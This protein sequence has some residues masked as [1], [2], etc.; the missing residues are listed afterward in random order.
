MV[1]ESWGLPWR[2]GLFAWLTRWE[3]RTGTHTVLS[4]STNGI[5]KKI[6]RIAKMIFI[7]KKQITGKKMKQKFLKENSFKENSH[8]RLN[9]KSNGPRVSEKC[10]VTK[11]RTGKWPLKKGV[12]ALEVSL[13]FPEP[14]FIYL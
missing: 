1:A 8:F 2:K 5:I 13:G 4:A 9:Q 10:S 7:G 3:G 6:K 12:Q 11:H 14:Q